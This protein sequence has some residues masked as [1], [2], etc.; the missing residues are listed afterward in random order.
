[1]SSLIPGQVDKIL[2]DAGVVYI[3]DNMIAPCEGDNSFVVTREYRDIPANG[4]P[5]PIK[6]LRRITK[7]TATMT[8]H[9]KG[10]TL[11]MLL[12]A[13][14]GARYEADKISSCGRLVIDDDQYHEVV[15]IG[16]SKDGTTKVI[17]LKNA[18]A[19]N[20]LNLTMSESAE[21]ILE[22][23]FDG[24]YD[25][26]DFSSPIYEIEDGVVAGTSAVTFSI[27][28]GDG[29]ATVKFA[30]RTISE[31]EGTAVF[32]SVAYG[33][34]RPYEVHEAGYVSVYGS[35]TVDGATEAVSVALE[36]VGA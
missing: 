28:G 3:D 30:G 12:L 15:L 4:A 23:V 24:C 19:N 25:P 5:G 26:S 21:A 36:A 16:N 7:E 34:N 11:A 9:P 31:T 29:G 1:M 10:L 14:P 6:G 35:V 27:T 18:I 22:L 17:T 32:S 2:L 8:V 20:G 13:L 33:A